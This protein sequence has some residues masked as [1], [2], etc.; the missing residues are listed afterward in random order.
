MAR[1]SEGW[2][3]RKSKGRKTYLVRF[4]VNGE[5]VERSTGTSDPVEADRAAARI[6]ADA[7]QRAPQELKVIRRGEAPALDDL[8]STWLASDATLD[9]DTAGVWE[10]YGRHWLAH[11]QTIADV[12]DVTAQDYRNARLRKVQGVTVR[13]ELGAL[14][15]FLRWCFERGYIPRE[16]NVPGVPA[17]ATGTRF[18]ER[19]RVEA[20]ELSPEQIEALI[21]AL[22]EWSTS[23]KVAPFP[24][25]ARFRV[26]YETGLRPSTIDALSVPEHWHDGADV[27]AV[28]PKID[29]VRNAR[30]VPLSPAAKAALAS[31]C[32]PKGGLLFGGHDYREHISKAAGAVLSAAVAAVFT[33]AHFRSAR[34]THLLERSGDVP[35]V[36]HLVGHRDARS[37]SRYLRP[38]FRAAQAA[39][40]AFGGQAQNTGG[41]RTGRPKGKKSKNPDIPAS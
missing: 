25:R 28:T 36:Q 2:Q 22:P 4:R 10:T 13:K 23:R 9:P 7:V 33:G 5:R 21:E 40:E 1:H 34:V 30:T 26:Q 19:R 6:Y 11:W 39:L 16:V 12:T 14:R 24:I 17:K 38:S 27:L 18:K 20:P 41:T 8:I 37:T 15:R 31:A 35:G 3:L 32:P 29:K